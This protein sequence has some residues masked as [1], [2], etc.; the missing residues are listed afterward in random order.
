MALAEELA[1]LLALNGSG[2]MSVLPPE[3]PLKTPDSLISEA[4]WWRADVCNSMI[5]SIT[6]NVNSTYW[7]SG[8]RTRGYH[9]A[10]PHQS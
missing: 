4:I 8:I 5:V 1:I 6:T 7:C 9:S 10:S 2:S 3:T